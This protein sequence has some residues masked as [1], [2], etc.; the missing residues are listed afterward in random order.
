[1]QGSWTMLR[2]VAATGLMRA[3]KNFV[4]RH[5]TTTVQLLEKIPGRGESGEKINVK[6]GYARNY[7]IPRGKAVYTGAKKEG[8]IV[9]KIGVKDLNDDGVEG[10]RSNS[11]KS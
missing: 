1:M 5:A 7:L 9:G 2:V 4:Y 10:R 11:Y 8:L 6:S 3:P